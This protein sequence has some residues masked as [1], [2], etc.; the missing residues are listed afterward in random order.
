MNDD[1]RMAESL[2]RAWRSYQGLAILRLKADVTGASGIPIRR[3]GDLVFAKWNSQPPFAK[4]WRI[5]EI[6]FACIMNESDVEV[7]ERP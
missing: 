1:L 7:L 3:A 5:L 2:L 4:G 6:G